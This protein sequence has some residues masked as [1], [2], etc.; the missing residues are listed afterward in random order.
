MNIAII[1]NNQK[2]IE[3]LKHALENKG[4]DFWF[5]NSAKEFGE[6]DLSKFN[7]IISDVLLSESNGRILLSSISDKTSADLYLMASDLKLFND[8][9]VSNN[10]I[11]G[12][13]DKCNLESFIKAIEYTDSK[14]R[15]KKN[16]EKERTVVEGLISKTNGYAL[17][18]KDGVTTIGLY[19]IMSDN[20]KSLIEKRIEELGCKNVIVYF[21]NS[22]PALSVY[23]PMLTYFYKFFNNKRNGNMVFCSNDPNTT[24]LIDECGLTRLFPIFDN[25]EKAREWV[26]SNS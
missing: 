24:R 12:F 7:I 8:S 20:S 5:F 19:S 17:D 14:L 18:C 6:S 15:I 4:W 16:I 9:D 11:S 25:I 10:C 3:I 22:T 21:A 26:K 23:L 13:I 2:D 1:E